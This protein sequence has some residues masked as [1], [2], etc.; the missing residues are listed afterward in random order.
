MIS[1]NMNVMHISSADIEEYDHYLG[2]N[3]R[4]DFVGL[5]FSFHSGHKTFMSENVE[6]TFGKEFYLC[7][8]L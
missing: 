1:Y 8:N 2:E 3:I 4:T 7:I 6:Q 5:I